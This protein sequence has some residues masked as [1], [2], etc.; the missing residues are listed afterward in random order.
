MVFSCT[1]LS[2][3]NSFAAYY[4]TTRADADDVHGCARSQG[5][6]TKKMY[7]TKQQNG[8]AVNLHVGSNNFTSGIILSAGE[9]ATLQHLAAVGPVPSPACS[10]P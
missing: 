9:L 5:K 6:L 7:G 8:Y 4:Q 2:A 1:K 3:H 10:F